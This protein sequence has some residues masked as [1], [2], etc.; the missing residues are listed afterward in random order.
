MSEE[1]LNIISYHTFVFPFLWD[2]GGKL[3][4]KG[5]EK[6]LIQDTN[7]QKDVLDPKAVPD[8]R[9]YAQQQYFN[10]AA[11]NAMFVRKND[12]QAAVHN[13]T[14]DFG[15]LLGDEGWLASEKNHTNPV[16]LLLEKESDGFGVGLSV[17]GV[18]LKL[19]NTGVG[20][21]LFE[22]SNYALSGEKNINKINEY[23]RRLFMPYVDFAGNCGDC[24]DTMTL[25]I[26]REKVESRISGRALTALD[27]VPLPEL[28][29]FFLKKGE[30]TVTANQKRGKKE[31]FIEPIIDDRMFTLCYYIDPDFVAAM[32]NWDEEN[33]CYAY[34]ADVQ[35][36]PTVCKESLARRMYEMMFVDGNGLT[37]HSRSMLAESLE[38]NLYT[39]WL[40]YTFDDGTC[41]GTVT[42]ITEYSMVTVSTSG[43]VA[44]TAF[45]PE[46]VEMACLVLAQRASLLAFEKRI[47]ESAKGKASISKIQRSYVI[48][49]GQLLLREVTP[50][51]QGIELYDLLLEQ[52]MI[53]KEAQ[54][55]EA[56]LNAMF[57]LEQTL[58]QQQE[59]LLLGV[60]AVISVFDAVRFFVEDNSLGTMLSG[61]GLAAVLALIFL[62]ARKKRIR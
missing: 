9:T 5:F 26:G 45:L 36:R 46:Y 33:Q 57:A 30:Y 49:Q 34:L 23:G 51:Q 55:I 43:F 14:Y 10:H 41:A 7:W 1:K 21:L 28:I 27:D 35:K 38:K 15:K 59:G 62:L 16:H 58:Q 25:R 60:L 48:F 17:R 42:G 6:K 32:A 37:C 39:R 44:E 56:Q 47:S 29:R 53:Q 31:L 54:E 20:L 61:G 13:F 12:T 40:G 3:T 52:L 24:V 50:Q 19:Y 4:R 2:Q 22:L 18:R 8:G 11:R